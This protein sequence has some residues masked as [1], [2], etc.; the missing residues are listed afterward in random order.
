[1]KKFTPFVA[2]LVALLF[3]AC[4]ND[5]N[6]NPGRLKVHA[7]YGSSITCATAAS[8]G[9][10]CVEGDIETESNLDV[11]GTATL[12]GAVTAGST[13]AATGAVTGASFSATA[14]DIQGSRPW[15]LVTTAETATTAD[16]GKIYASATHLQTVLLPAVATANAGCCVT[17]INTAASGA[18]FVG[19][20]VNASDAVFG[21]IANAGQDS[22][23]SGT[24]DEAW[25]NTKA[26]AIKGDRATLCSDGSTG[27]FIMEGVGIWASAAQ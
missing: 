22:A 19:F 20:S 5:T 23:A 24:D 21:E 27:W 9:E 1:M 2:L 26:T 15:E 10:V 11:A 8:D 12:T 18:A 16:C 7:T 25:G 6:L 17:L 14:G 3:G 13:V 4:A